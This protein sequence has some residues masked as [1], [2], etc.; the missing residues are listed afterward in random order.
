MGAGLHT[1]TATLG[2]VGK[3]LLATGRVS[4]TVDLG[5]CSTHL[6]CNKQARLIL[7]RDGHGVAAGLLERYRRE[8]DLGVCW[9]DSGWGSVHHFYHA[10]TGDGL[11]GRAPADVVG[12]RYFRRAFDLWRR[13]SY[14]K[15]MFFLGAATHLLQDLC[16]PH[17]ASC[18][19]GIGHACYERWV[20]KHSGSFL[21]GERGI[22]KTFREP[23]KWFQYCARKSYGLFDLV[24]ERSN[25]KSYRQ[26]TEYLLPLTQRITAGFW[27]NFFKQVGVTLNIKP[28]VPVE[29]WACK[30]GPK[31]VSVTLQPSG[32]GKW[33][34]R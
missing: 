4:W 21:S 16:E 31:P 8:L 19:W 26:A 25:V 1:F 17:H 6:L 2:F 24:R 5:F 15:A 22:Y 32:R 11:L 33:P 20:Q 18:V 14:G 29:G 28:I 9:P 10:R 3:Y 7:E 13:G 12:E 34:P 30:T 27:L 23:V